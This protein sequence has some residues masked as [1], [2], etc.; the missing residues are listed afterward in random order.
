MYPCTPEH[1]DETN[2]IAE[3]FMAVIAKIV[4]AAIAEGNYPKTGTT[5]FD[6]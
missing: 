2:G 5:V 6:E 1:P 4:H 3:R